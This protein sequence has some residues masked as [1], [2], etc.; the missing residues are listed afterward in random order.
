MG[1]AK[2]VIGKNLKDLRKRAGLKQKD[3]VAALGVE[4]PTVSRWENGKM[5]PT[6][7]N[8]Q[9]LLKL[10]NATEAD[11]LRLEKDASQAF[12]TDQIKALGI[13][14]AEKLKDDEFS[15]RTADERELLS[16]FRSAPDKLKVTILKSVRGLLKVDSAAGV[17]G[18]TARRQRG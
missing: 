16:L 10:Y 6:E 13:Q 17:A 4:A 2:T 11:L 5:E 7:E 8:K 18:T 12:S 9:A 3:V 1:F 15:A 14:I